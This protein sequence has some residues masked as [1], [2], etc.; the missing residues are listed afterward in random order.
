M[1]PDGKDAASA[2]EETLLAWRRPISGYRN[3]ERPRGRFG[4]QTLRF[5]MALFQ[6]GRVQR[7]FSPV[8]VQKPGLEDI[9]RSTFRIQYPLSPL[10]SLGNSDD[11]PSN[12]LTFPPSPGGP[13][14]LT[15]REKER[16]RERV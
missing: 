6:R 14:Q 12:A 10:F 1:H 9:A 2:V 11:G 8:P 5:F 15:R 4:M 16:E 13:I 3:I 7:G